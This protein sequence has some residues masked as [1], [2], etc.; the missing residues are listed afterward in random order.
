MTPSQNGQIVRFHTPFPG[1]NP[2]QLYI[3]LEAFFDVEKPRALIKAL[4]FGTSL[5]PTTTV[6]IED[7]EIITFNIVEV[8]GKELKI[9][10]D[11]GSTMAGIVRDVIN[12]EAVLILQK[13][14]NEIVSNI[15]VTV[16][17]QNDRR[18]TGLMLPEFLY[19]Y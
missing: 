13:I 1:E 4:G 12:P 15:K 16:S 10:L 14:D 6:L 8:T 9:K 7:L 17:D 2:D 11:D 5:A 3:I 19:T 18:L